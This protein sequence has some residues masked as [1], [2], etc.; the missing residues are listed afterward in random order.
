[1]LCV[2][3]F[4]TRR[5]SCQALETHCDW[6]TVP[7]LNTFLM[8]NNISTLDCC[9]I[10][11]RRQSQ[12]L[13]SLQTI[14]PS[15]VINYS[16]C[17]RAIPESMWTQLLH[18]SSFN[19]LCLHTTCALPLIQWQ[20][21]SSGLAHAGLCICNSDTHATALS[22]YLVVF[23]DFQYLRDLRTQRTTWTP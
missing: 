12:L 15:C 6:M 22:A 20:W 3:T 17:L 19:M 10:T 23:D 21:I 4:R 8:Q 5:H 13:P 1:M 18:T 9:D 16:V 2:R 11:S 7:E 14:L